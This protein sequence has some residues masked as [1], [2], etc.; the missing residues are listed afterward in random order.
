MRPQYRDDYGFRNNNRNNSPV[1]LIVIIAVAL[2]IIGA[3][4]WWYFGYRNTH[5]VLTDTIAAEKTTEILNS[6]D[7]SAQQTGST[8]T[9]L[10]GAVPASGTASGGASANTTGDASP[11]G[12]ASLLNRPLTYTGTVTPGGVASLN[13]ILFQNGRLEGSIDYSGGKSMQLFGSYNWNDDGHIMDIRFTVCSDSDKGYSESWSGQ[14]S[15][16][17]DNLAHT[18]TFKNINTSKGQSMTASFALRQ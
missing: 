6:G 4:C 14:S 3:G 17:K 8:S 15:Y 16:I 18:L 12:S 5:P 11:M 1:L 2:L 7:N 10:P 9:P 13:I